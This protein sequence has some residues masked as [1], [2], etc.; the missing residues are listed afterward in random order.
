MINL[1]FYGCSFSENITGYTICRNY[2]N[3]ISDEISYNNYS[4][5]SNSNLKILDS[6][7][8]NLLPNSISV[9]QWSALT[10]PN[11]SNF[12]KIENSV[13]PLWDLLDEWYTYIDIATE[14]ALQNNIKL[15]QYIGWAQWRDDELN[16]YHRT[17]LNS[18]DIHWFHS[19]SEF[20][21]IQSNC[22]QFGIPHNWSSTQF[23]NG[24]FRWPELVWGG[25]SE[26]IRTNIKIENRYMGYNHKHESKHFDPHPSEYGT[27]RFLEYFLIPEVKLQNNEKNK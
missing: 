12:S 10:R 9:I 11:D 19:K 1:N 21:K 15:I 5:V 8:D 20:D 18:Y 14:L 7:K 4:R 2:L 26:W 17:K 27:L 23:D 3:E 24:L 6:F 16:E 22:F 13:N 25:M